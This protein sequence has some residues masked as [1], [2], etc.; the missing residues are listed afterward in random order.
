MASFAAFIG[1]G[2]GALAAAIPVSAGFCGS[3]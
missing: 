2:M 1:V 3:S